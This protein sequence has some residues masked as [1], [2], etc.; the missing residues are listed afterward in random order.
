MYRKFQ[1]I[2]IITALVLV[3]G[4]G[5][6]LQGAGNNDAIVGQLSRM[7]QLRLERLQ[8]M[9]QGFLEEIAAR[10]GM[11]IGTVKTHIRR[12]LILLRERLQAGEVM[13]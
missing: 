10:T 7:E 5:A 11:P 1:Y 6:R 8:S 9:D 13:A 2:C 12:G 4:S 3:A